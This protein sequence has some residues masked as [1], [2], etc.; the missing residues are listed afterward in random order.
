MTTE[1]EIEGRQIMV[2]HAYL[3]AALRVVSD[4]PA[5][6]NAPPEVMD[7]LDEWVSALRRCEHKFG[8]ALE[9]DIHVTDHW[10]RSMPKIFAEMTAA[11]M[12]F[13]APLAA[14]ENAWWAQRISELERDDP[15]EPGLVEL[16]PGDLADPGIPVDQEAG[17]GIG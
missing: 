9:A 7:G 14:W 6:S 11:H 17:H 2:M 10:A 8:E 1:T 13:A 4:Q 16:E 15:L 5:S 3:A 12:A